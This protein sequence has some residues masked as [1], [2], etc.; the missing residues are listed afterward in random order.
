MTGGGAHVV[1]D[2]VGERGAEHDGVA[3]TRAAGSY[4]VVG[5]GGTLEVPTMQMITTEISLVGNLVGTYVD[6]V[7]LLTPAAQGKV[8][9]HTQTYPLEAAVEA[10]HDLEEGRL[11]GRGILVP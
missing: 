8:A 10:M 7:D 11:Q 5:Y 2:F 9:L 1:L 4:S 6:L 3:M